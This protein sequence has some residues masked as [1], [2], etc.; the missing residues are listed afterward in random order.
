MHWINQSEK[1]TAAN[2]FLTN[3]SNLKSQEYPAPVLG[4]I[5]LCF[6]E[7]RFTIHGFKGGYV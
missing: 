2:Q 6:A 7:I 1:D 3:N 5:F 4:V